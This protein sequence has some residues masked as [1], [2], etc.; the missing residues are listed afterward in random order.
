MSG[1]FDRLREHIRWVLVTIALVVLAATWGALNHRTGAPHL[2]TAG[3]H[4]HPHVGLVAGQEGTLEPALGRGASLPNGCRYAGSD[5]A[6]SHIVAR[7]TCPDQPQP[8]TLNLYVG[9]SQGRAVNGGTGRFSA[10]TPAEFPPALRNAI[11][12]RI[13]QRETHFAWQLQGESP[14]ASRPGR[15]DGATFRS[16]LDL[17]GR[18]PTPRILGAFAFL[19]AYVWRLLRAESRRVAWLLAA[20][21]LAGAALRLFLAVDA[22]MNAHSFSR[23]LP[24]A[25]DLFRGPLLT[26]LSGR[27]G[28]AVY[29]TTV[30]GWANYAL[31]VAMPLVFFAH[32]RLL[33]GDSRA[34]LVA[35]V[36]MAFLPMHIRFS[37]SDVTFIASLLNSSFTFVVLYGWL[38][39]PS[40]AWRIACL[41]LLPALSLATY[42]ARPENFIFV[43]LDLGALSLYLGKGIPRHR[44]LI[45][46]T[47]IAA[48]AGYSA[49]TDLMVRYEHTV[50][51][52]L[53]IATLRSAVG[54]FL[55]R[56]YNTLIN[57]WMTPPLL[58]VLAAV[59]GAALWRG[60][61]RRRALFLV[62][63]LATFFVVNSFVRP[64]AV[65]MQARYHL[66][67]VSPLLLLAAAAT[68]RVLA[69][70][71]T[72]QTALL[73]WVLL[74]PALHAGFIRDVNYTEMHEYAFLRRVR[75][76]IG[77]SCTVLELGP[78]MESPHPVNIIIQRSGRM[79]R[80][81]RGGAEASPV[82][83]Q[84]GIIPPDATRPG[85]WEV[86]AP[87]EDFV[88]HPPAC[89]YYYEN[90]ACTTHRAGPGRLAP[91]CEEMH[92]RFALTL[93]AEER[94]PLH[95]YDSIILDRVMTW[96]N[97]TRQVVPLIRDPVE[98]HL[99]LYHV[100]G[101]AD[102]RTP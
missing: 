70:P 81:L 84:L 3:F 47:V 69:L 4:E 50:S 8:L 91:V 10:W 92:R 72:A 32:A 62:T 26:W 78:A 75:G 41:A 11:F 13:R 29:F 59:G 87:P 93:I 37:R 31:A 68:P 12:A 45:A 9:A 73:A 58:P 57:P 83:R 20:T 63:W 18:D 48:T 22:P 15:R 34:A 97:G 27:M 67:L 7:Y 5:I 21:V 36:L 52:G 17:L 2:T 61:Q 79:T 101:T 56:R 76:R 24:L 40:R 85:V 90:A 6:P 94:H 64:Y 30:Q 98:V 100:T 19:L 102:G 28:F 44:L 39:D 60:G 89:L 65:V 77:P 53:S 95:A 51:E 54:I 14:T 35:A 80:A 16:L 71:Q 66:N 38:T 33:L 1:L 42:Q 49:V 88:A 96:P 74:A 99:G 82:V 46:G 43:G 23:I 55:D 86:F 25:E